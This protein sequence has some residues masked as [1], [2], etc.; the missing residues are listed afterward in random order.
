[1]HPSI[2]QK[3]C[4]YPILGESNKIFARKILHPLF[5]IDLSRSIH[6]RETWPRKKSGAPLSKVPKCFVEG[7]VGSHVSKYSFL[8]EK[9]HAIKGV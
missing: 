8:R 1:M 2:H 3:K 4:S 9:D 6:F 5:Q 7:K